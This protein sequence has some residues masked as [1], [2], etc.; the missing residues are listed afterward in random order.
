MKISKIELDNFRQYYGKVEFE[1]D[2]DSKKNIV[3]IVGVNG[4]GK[5]NLYNAIT[6]CLYG[7]EEHSKHRVRGL[8]RLSERERH[9]LANN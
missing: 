9:E 1:F 5:S 2:T 7:I 3:V 6:W 8:G 4:A